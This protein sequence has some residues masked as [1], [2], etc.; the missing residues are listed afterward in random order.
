VPASKWFT[1]APMKMMFLSLKGKGKW[2]LALKL[3]MDV[4][5]PIH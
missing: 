2:E 3:L 1:K 5:E 4:V